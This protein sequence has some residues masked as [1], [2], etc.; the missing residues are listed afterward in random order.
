MLYDGRRN[1]GLSDAGM[2]LQPKDVRSAEIGRPFLDP[3]QKIQASSFKTFLD[4]WTTFEIR[5]LKVCEQGAVL[6][7][8]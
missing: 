7:Q 4:T 3:F 8:L 1:R 2:P 5:R 6:V